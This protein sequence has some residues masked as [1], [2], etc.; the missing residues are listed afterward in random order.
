MLFK[1]TFFKENF[2]TNIFTSVGFLFKFGY[3]KVL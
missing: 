2:K 1:L 3:N